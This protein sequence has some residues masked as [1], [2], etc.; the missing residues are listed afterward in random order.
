M[1]TGVGRLRDSLEPGVGPLRDLCSQQVFE[2]HLLGME[3]LSQGR[4]TSGYEKPRPLPEAY[5]LLGESVCGA[6]KRKF[7]HAE[8]RLLYLK[9]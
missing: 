8:L 1:G 4:G 6:L 7:N 9:K 3:A 5:R 2:E